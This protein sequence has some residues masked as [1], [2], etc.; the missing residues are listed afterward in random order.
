MTM[1]TSEIIVTIVIW[2]LT[3]AG[4]FFCLRAAWRRRKKN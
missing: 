1:T 3:I 4:T 2:A